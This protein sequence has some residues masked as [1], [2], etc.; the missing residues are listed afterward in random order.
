MIT[1]DS[2]NIEKAVIIILVARIIAKFTK[3]LSGKSLNKLSFW[4]KSQRLFL[5]NIKCSFSKAKLKLKRK[6][7]DIKKVK[8]TVNIAPLNILSATRS[9]FFERIKK[10]SKIITEI[11]KIAFSNSIN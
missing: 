5:N 8:I 10:A 6:R 4:L 7:M 1:C 11:R 2:T 3:K 9:N